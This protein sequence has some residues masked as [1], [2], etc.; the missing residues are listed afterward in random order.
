MWFASISLCVEQ[1]RAR[2]EYFFA[3]KPLQVFLCVKMTVL[4]LLKQEIYGKKRN[5]N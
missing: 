4:G 2:L 5:G 1:I 3:F